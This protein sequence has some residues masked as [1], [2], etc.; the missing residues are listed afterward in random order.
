[1]HQGMVNP[2]TSKLLLEIMF[3]C[4]LSFLLSFDWSGEA[5]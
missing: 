4:M 3:Q 1:M 2:L 5:F